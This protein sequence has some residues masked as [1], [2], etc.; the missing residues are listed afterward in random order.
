VHQIDTPEQRWADLRAI[1]EPPPLTPD[2]FLASREAARVKLNEVFSGATRQLKVETRFPN[3]VKD[4][5]AAYMATIAEDAKIDTMGRCLVI[6]SPEAWNAITALR[7]AHVLIADFDVDVSEG[8]ILLD[9]ARRAGHAVVFGSMPGG[10]PHPNAVPIPNP[11]SYQVQEALKKAGYNEERARI[12]A[13]KSDG[14]LNTLLRCLQ[15]LSIMPEWAQATDAAELVIAEL[16]GA[17][18]EG[19][20]ADRA[21]VEKLSGKVYGEW[22]GIIREITFR[23]GAPLIHREGVWKM[24]ARYEGWYSLGPRLFDNH[25]DLLKEVATIVLRER[26]PKLELPVEKRFTALVRGK[27]QSYSRLLRAGL[28]ESLALLGSHSKALTSCSTGK[29]EATAVLTVRDVLEGADWVLWAS[30]NDFLALLA[31]AAPGEFLDAVESALNSEASPF[32]AVFAQ[33]GVGVYGSNYTTG[34]LWALETLAWDPEHLT[35]VVVLLGELAARDPGGNWGNRPERSLCTILLPWLPQTCAPVSKRRTAVATLLGEFPDVAWKLLLAMMPSA[36]EISTRT[37]KPAWREMIPDEW[38]E[39]VTRQEYREQVLAYSEL[40]IDAAKPDPT[41][42]AELVAHLDDFLPQSRDRLL[43]HLGSETVLSMAREDRLR[44]WTALVDL[45]SKHTRFADA[46]WAMRPEVLSV[47]T[48]V[49]ERLSPDSPIYLHQRLFGEREVGLYEKKGDYEEQQKQLDRRRQEAV[50]EVFALGGMEAV[51]EFAKAVESPWRAGF[52]FGMKSNT[53]LDKKILPS[54]LESESKPLAQFAGGYVWARFR[55]RGWNWIDNINTSRWAPSQKGQLLAYLPFTHDAWERSTRFL[56]EDES[57]YWSKAS[58]NPYQVEGGL[59][60]AIDRLLKHDRPYAALGCLGR[61]LHGGQ[62]L[63]SQQAVRVL[64]AVRD[65][66]RGTQ[67]LDAHHV[68]E[69]IEALQKNLETNAEDLYQLEWAFLPLLNRHE[70]ASPKLLEQR[71][72]DDPAFFC[73]VIRT[74]FRSKKEA[75]PAEELP[76]ERQKIAENAFRLLHEWKTP[77]G[78]RKGGTYDGEALTDWLKQVKAACAETG[79]LEVALSSVGQVLTH[80]PPDPDGL[81][82]H[83]SAA[84]ELN[85]RDANDM[86]DGFRNQLFN[87]RGV[88]YSTGGH[89]ERE[90]ADRYR[91]Q[92]EG[93]ESRSYHRLAKSLRELADSYVRDAERQAASDPFGD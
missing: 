59:E 24:A 88:Y 52:A 1:G 28:A 64:Q 72:A 91:S 13:Q 2:V 57:P 58:A 27:V 31:E 76:I 71:L 20:E 9:R 21:V 67:A 36:Q 3:Q 8:A 11:N 16:L 92:A 17:W 85:A 39:G 66:P 42:L 44:L 18:N 65:S 35:R 93:L 80:A 56:G 19:A 50:H 79:H 60:L 78:S 89:E 61:V 48:S 14:N 83:H 47:V 62:T 81:W 87:S 41:K 69:V 82:P 51:L 54:L 25:L 73:E 26:D 75:R 12:L 77:P 33:E 43:A 38:T 86:R 49:A 10:I 32:D 70:G 6:S 74:V 90:L 55:A 5:V 84:R 23:P 15:N 4:F 34:L 7:D 29:S 37:R 63:N 40:A 30:L 45:V 22:I 46:N 68:S 53:K